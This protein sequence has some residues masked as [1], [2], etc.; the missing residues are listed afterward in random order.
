[1][2]CGTIIYGNVFYRVTRAAFIGGGRDNIVENNIFVECNPAVHVD[3]RAMGWASYHV[4]TT[5]VERLNRVPY[6]KPPWSERY[7]ELVN[8]LEDEPAAPKGNR[9]IRNVCWRGKWLE[10]EG[11]AKPY[12]RFE[13]NLIDQN[14]LFVDAEKMDFR[15][16]P[17][18]PAYKIGFK[19][20]PFEKIGLY[21]SNSP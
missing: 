12:V 20:I 8:I 10:I 4:N 17:D 11:K 15:L 14:P 7:P 21:R 5:M 3:A 9:I 2:L 16:R 19:P 6:K 13:E 1:M 18:S